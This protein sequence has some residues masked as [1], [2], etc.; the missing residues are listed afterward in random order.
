MVGE[1]ALVDPVARDLHDPPAMVIGRVLLATGI[2]VEGPGDHPIFADAESY[3]RRGLEEAQGASR[4]EA[5]LLLQELADHRRRIAAATPDAP[6]ETPAQTAD[7]T[8]IE[9]TATGRPAAHAGRGQ[10]VPQ[11]RPT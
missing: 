10:D 11:R 6:L 1:E 5:A 2:G 9:T 8:A 7:G 4:R 3:L